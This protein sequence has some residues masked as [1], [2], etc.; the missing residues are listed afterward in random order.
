MKFIV[1]S[2]SATIRRCGEG[3]RTIQRRHESD[4][5]GGASELP[6]FAGAGGQVGAV[7]VWQEQV[8]SLSCA[9]SFG[10]AFRH[11]KHS[12]GYYSEFITST[13]SEWQW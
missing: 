4:E 9:I 7:L 5:H 8:S 6:S 2:P 12:P 1:E 3:Y 13:R 11:R 10:N